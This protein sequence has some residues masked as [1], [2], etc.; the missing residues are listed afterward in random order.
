MA[1][2]YAKGDT[3]FIENWGNWPDYFVQNDLI[4]GVFS[5]NAGDPIYFHNVTYSP[6]ENTGIEYV[7]IQIEMLIPQDTL[8]LGYTSTIY[9][10]YPNGDSIWLDISD[11]YDGNVIYIKDS[12]VSI[13]ENFMSQI[14]FNIFPNPV[15][16]KLSINYIELNNQN[17]KVEIY[18]ISG[19]LINKYEINGSNHTIDVTAISPGIYF[20]KIRDGNKTGIKRFVVN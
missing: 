8:V 13:A 17:I 4:Y 15:N 19:L 5:C 7:N 20:L 1:Y 2:F 11:P 16:S 12:T 6:D 18:N 9:T 14:S 3:L 10:E